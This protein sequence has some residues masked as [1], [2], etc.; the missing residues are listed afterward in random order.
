VST[1]RGGK[2]PNQPDNEDADGNPVD[3][4]GHC[5]TPAFERLDFGGHE[6]RIEWVVRA[7]H[8]REAQG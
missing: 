4:L 2:P 6:H 7:V 8:F 5:L 3:D 1:L